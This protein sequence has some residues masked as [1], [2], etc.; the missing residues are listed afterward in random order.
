MEGRAYD[1][2]EL[3]AK[4]KPLVSRG[5]LRRYYRVARPGRWYGGIATADCCGCCLRCVFCWSGHPRDHPES[6]EF[7][8]PAEVFRHLDSC[9]SKHGYGLLRVS[10][11]EPTLCPEH[12]LELLQLV[13][14]SR[15]RFILET[16]GIL[17]DGS[18]ARKLSGFRKLHVRVSLKGTTEQEFSKLTGATP[19]SFNLQLS[20]LKHL[21]DEGVSCHPAV[22]L[23]FSEPEGLEGLKARLADIDSK[24]PGQLEEEYVFLYP[25]V[26]ERLKKAGLVP[27]I[28]YQ[29]NR[30]PCEL[31]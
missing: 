2:L 30:V 26:T 23:S 25:H 21:L 31:I 27:K 15:Y 6:G 3:A 4:I 5:D 17:I 29:P 1:P 20:A 18:Y 11:N 9:A 8:D 12:L 16:N 28:S 13:E 14:N 7:Y 19:A 10:G 24:L 22:M